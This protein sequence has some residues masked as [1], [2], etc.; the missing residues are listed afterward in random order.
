MQGMCTALAQLWELELLP[1]GGPRLAELWYPSLSSTAAL[2][3]RKT[4]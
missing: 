4:Y 3:F 2:L 1:M